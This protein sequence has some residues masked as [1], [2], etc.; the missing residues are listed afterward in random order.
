MGVRISSPALT[1]WL[2][3]CKFVDL[4]EFQFPCPKNGDNGTYGVDLSHK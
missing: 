3:Q 1:C 4:S 2:T